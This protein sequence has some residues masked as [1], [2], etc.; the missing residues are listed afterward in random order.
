MKV[1]FILTAL[2]AVVV[3]CAML[4]RTKRAANTAQQSVAPQANRVGSVTG[5]FKAEE[6]AAPLLL[7]ADVTHPKQGFLAE[8][9][10]DLSPGELK[11]L[12]WLFRERLKAALQ[13][14]AQA[15]AGRIPFNP[16]E[17]TMD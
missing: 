14:W 6:A 12:E 10:A 9:K 5:E 4:P 15:Y 17:V 8:R 11:Q 7:A 16:E 3:I 2:A 1:R 13:R